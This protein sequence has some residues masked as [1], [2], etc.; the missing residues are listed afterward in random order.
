MRNIRKFSSK[1]L[2]GIL[3]IIALCIGI[4]NA[5]KND[6]FLNASITELLTIIIAIIFSYWFVQIKSDKRKK[7][8]KID[9]MIYKIQ[10]IVSD[11]EFLSVETD[12]ICRKNLIAHRSVGNKITYLK[13]IC[14]DDSDI[15]VKVLELENEFNGFR[16]FYGNHYCDKQY[17]S[18]SEKDLLNYVTKIDDKADEIHTLT[19]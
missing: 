19:L 9:T 16:E 14:E 13:K 7:N 18:K 11:P 8:E 15:K 5:K 1:I 17:M 2:T 4:Y 10:S 12:Q 3:L 6:G